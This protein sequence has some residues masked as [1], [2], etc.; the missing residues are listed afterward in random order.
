[1]SV[2]ALDGADTAVR[3]PWPIRAITWY[4][5]AFSWR[6]SPCRFT[7]TCS[8]YALEAY[9]T[10]GT[11]RGTWLT[12]RRLAR[13]RPF[14]PS[15]WDPVPDA[16]HGRHRVDVG[17]DHHRVPEGENHREHHDCQGGAH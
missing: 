5:S 12:I 10:Y 17:S 2:D 16:D 3:T 4:Q 14:G 9:E 1:M 15:G 13:C 11:G 6:P 7:P 8:N